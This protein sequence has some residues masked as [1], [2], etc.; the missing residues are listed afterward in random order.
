MHK[1]VCNHINKYFTILFVNIIEHIFI[2]FHFNF[3]SEK[4]S[5]VESTVG[6]LNFKQLQSLSV[7]SFYVHE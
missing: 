6:E 1:Y 5:E 3:C 7:F 2:A 4:P